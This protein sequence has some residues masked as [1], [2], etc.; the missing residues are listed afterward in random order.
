MENKNQ[1]EN[2]PKEVNLGVKKSLNAKEAV[3]R[4][5]SMGKEKKNPVNSKENLKSTEESSSSPIKNKKE[6]STKEKEAHDP[7]NWVMISKALFRFTILFILLT[8]F[9]FYVVSIDKKNKILGLFEQENYAIQ[10]EK[11]QNR[12]TEKKS[13]KIRLSEQI[14]N[15]EKG[16]QN[17]K[18]AI[19]DQMV[20]SRLN[21][22]DLIEKVNE[23]T[24]SVYERNFLTQYVQYTNYTFD[25]ERN[26]LSLSGVLSDPLGKNLTK[27]A[28]LELAFENYPKLP[29]EAD[30]EVKPYFYEVRGFEAF[31]KNLNASTGRF[32]SSFSVSMKTKPSSDLTNS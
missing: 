22:T 19:I 30:S 26:E 17:P 23:V 15:F 28:E 32:D 21:W 3:S 14:K 6:N 12:L 9:F 1:I 24:Q 5:F 27:L 18:V 13:E 29:K 20:D 31:S 11:L 8:S 7:L 16:Y 2:Q 25:A 10:L 4:W